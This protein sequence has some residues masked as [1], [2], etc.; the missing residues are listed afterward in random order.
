MYTLG[1]DLHKEFALWSLID[2]KGNNLWQEKVATNLELVSSKAKEL[3]KPCQAVLEPVGC[4][5]LYAEKLKEQE[6]DTHLAHPSKVKLIA[7]TK[8]KN[9]KIDATVLAQLLRTNFLPEAYLPSKNIRQLR[10]FLLLRNQIVANRTRAKNRM[11]ML[12]T[13]WGIKTNLTDLFGKKGLEFLKGLS[14]SYLDKIQRDELIRVA[15]TSNSQVKN[16]NCVLEKIAESDD[17]VQRMKTVPNIGTITA[18][19]IKAYVGKFNRFSNASK[20]VS[21]AGLIPSLRQSGNSIKSGH[22]TKQGPSMLRAVLVQAAAGIRSSA[23]YLYHYYKNKSKKIG[24][25][26]AR[27]ALA[28]KLLTI[29]Y[30]VVK[31]K[32]VYQDKITKMGKTCYIRSA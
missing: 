27:I 1:I 3:P 14:L 16:L 20:L 29:A 17:N 23:G 18:L 4:F 8:I 32:T 19:T 21:Y 11:R 6:I 12:L 22:I 13:Q 9:D 30:R 26:K 2:K 7:E 25:K 5:A 28:K 15:A 31:D 10:S 24:F